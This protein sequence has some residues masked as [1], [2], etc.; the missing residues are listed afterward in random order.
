M[1]S[2]SEERGPRTGR[3]PN[4]KYESCLKRELTRQSTSSSGPTTVKS[5]SGGGPLVLQNQLILILAPSFCVKSVAGKTERLPN[6]RLPVD[7]GSATR[8]IS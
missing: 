6:P 4:E 2:P 3:R 5:I 7:D 8:R 1:Q